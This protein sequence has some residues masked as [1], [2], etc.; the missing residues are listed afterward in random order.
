MNS[1]KKYLMNQTEIISIFTKKT[2]G[3]TFALSA[4]A[5]AF[6]QEKAS[7][8]GTIVDKRNNIIHHNDEA[9]DITFSDL[10]SHIDFFLEYMLSIDQLLNS[11]YR[12]A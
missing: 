1:F 8:T 4:A 11:R 10:R 12:Y 7:V 6:G 9:S 2:L 3:L 5:F